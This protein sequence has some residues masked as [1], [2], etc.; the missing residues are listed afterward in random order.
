MIHDAG[1]HVYA[2]QP[3]SFNEH[4]Q[5]ILESIDRIIKTKPFQIIKPSD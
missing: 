4:V 5:E 1:H 3:Q 2:D